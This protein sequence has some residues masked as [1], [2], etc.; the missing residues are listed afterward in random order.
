[1]NYYNSFL[2]SSF[3]SDGHGKVL[4]VDA[5]ASLRCAIM[6]DVM[7]A[8]GAS[9]GWA[10]VVINGCVRDSADIAKVDIGVKALATTPRKTIKRQQ[11]LANIVVHFADVIFQ[12]NDYLYADEDGIVLSQVPLL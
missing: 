10:G 12:P 1:M 6:G 4:V 9:H 11:G 7:A 8:L 2:K 5:A 3:E